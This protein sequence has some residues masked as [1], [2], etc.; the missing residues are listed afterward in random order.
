MKDFVHT[1]LTRRGALMRSV[2]F[3]TGLLTAG[4]LNR[5]SAQT[6]QTGFSGQGLHFLALGDYGSGNVHQTTVAAQM[7]AFAKKLD[8]PLHA[9][10]AL[11]DNFYGRLEPDRFQRHFEDMYSKKDFNCPFYACLGNHDYGPKY[12]SKQG[13]DKAQMQL[14]YAKNNPASRWK[15]PER[16]YSVELPDAQ[17]PLVKII[18]LDGNVF[19]GA[20]TPQ[21]KLA[22]KRWLDA[23]LQKPTR[24]PWRWMISHYPIYSDG[25][26]KDNPKLIE[27]WGALVKEHGYSFYFC[28]HDHN[29]QHLQPADNPAS[30]VISG[31]GGAGLYDLQS[32]HRTFAE[33][34][35]GFTHLHVSPQQVNVQYID[36]DGHLLHAFRRTSEGKV[37]VTSK[38]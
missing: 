36:A 15:M 21:E 38:A 25:S 29:L 18:F 34:I 9:V 35:L 10:L 19:E 23:E 7:A 5:L 20:L 14:D 22:Q 2:L 1:P 32:V 37:T 33:K 8:S 24:A 13:R 6:A 12:D 28:G 16:W 17:N 3:S 26:Y 31:A 4:W 11:G 30:F 27:S